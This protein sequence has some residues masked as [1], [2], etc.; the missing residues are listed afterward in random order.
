MRLIVFTLISFFYLYG[1]AH[2]F[3]YH[4][5]GDDRYPST[6]TSINELKSQFNYFKTNGYKVVPLSQIFEKIDKNQDIPDNWIVLTIDDNY[7]SFY[8]NALAIFKEYN[9]P[10]TIFVSVQATN[11]KF[12]DFMTWDNLKEAKKYGDVEFHSF[13]HPHM[14]HLG[15]Q[16]IIEDTKNGLDIFVKNMGYTPK[17]FAY[18]FGEYDDRVKNIFKIN[19]TFDG[20]LNQAPGG[21]TKYSDKYDL[22]R[23]PL[24]GNVNLKEHLKYSSLVCVE[25]IEPKEYPKNM[26]LTKIKAKTNKNIN[27]IMLFVSGENKWHNLDIRN[28]EIDANVNIKLT[29]DRTRVILSTDYYK[30]TTKLLVK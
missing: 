15:N 24:V 21:T 7:R 23:F 13:A 5:F 8:T 10:F 20:I 3:I 1:D 26:I 25:W 16:Q 2:I 9:Y 6:N 11:E 19:F 4:R 17:Y 28:G 14:T 30:I 29:K 12:G 18:P 22:N 27:K